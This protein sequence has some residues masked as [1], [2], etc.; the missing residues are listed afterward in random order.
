MIESQ[1]SLDYGAL[2]SAAVGLTVASALLYAAVG[3][4][5][6]IVLKRISDR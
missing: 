5:E 2:W 3:W 1:H 6:R 4:L